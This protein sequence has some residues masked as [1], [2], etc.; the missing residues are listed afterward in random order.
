MIKKIIKSILVL[1]ASVFMS[2]I[3]FMLNFGFSIILKKIIV[4]NNFN[5]DLYGLIVLALMLTCFSSLAY[6]YNNTYSIY[7]ILVSTIAGLLFLGIESFDSYYTNDFAI[8]NSWINLF[9][10]DNFDSGEEPIAHRVYGIITIIFPVL[11]L[12]SILITNK[13]YLKKMNNRNK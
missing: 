7:A 3:V 1:I 12:F 4:V 13:L 6:K 10:W 5:N 2:C 11:L 9:G 8:T